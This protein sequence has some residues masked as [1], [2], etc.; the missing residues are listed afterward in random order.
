MAQGATSN[1]VKSVEMQVAVRRLLLDGVE[2]EREGLLVGKRVDRQRRWILLDW[3]RGVS[4]VL[5]WIRI[6]KGIC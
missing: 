1:S 6:G 4:G 3:G 5:S 2:V